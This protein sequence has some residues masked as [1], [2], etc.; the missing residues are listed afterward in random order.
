[1]AAT[2]EII[3]Q[4]PTTDVNSSG[5]VERATEIT[6]RTKPSHQVGRVVIFESAYTPE[7]AAARVS[8]AVQVIETVQTS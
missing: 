6:F 8:A 3:S 2:Y 1:M 4:V 5:R 7:E